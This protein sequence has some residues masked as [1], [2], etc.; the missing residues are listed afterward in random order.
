MV[1]EVYSNSAKKVQ[2]G[3]AP[4]DTLRPACPRKGIRAS[5][6]GGCTVATRGADGRDGPTEAAGAIVDAGTCGLMR[7]RGVDPVAALEAHD[8]HP[9]LDQAGALLRLG[10]TGTNLNDVAVAL[11]R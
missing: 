2:S 10:L 5:L 11:V 9:A 6:E 3:N 1:A 8:A 4:V 7:A